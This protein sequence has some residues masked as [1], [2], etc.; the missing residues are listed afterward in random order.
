[1][2]TWTP[3]EPVLDHHGLAL[4]ADF[5]GTLTLTI[6]LYNPDT[7]ERVKTSDGR[8]AVEIATVNVE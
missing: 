5:R 1:M 4:P 2:T 6:G 3:N 7:G 8:D